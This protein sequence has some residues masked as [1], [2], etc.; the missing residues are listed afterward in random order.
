MIA[1][2]ESSGSRVSCVRSSSLRAPSSTL[3]WIGVPG[4]RAAH[5]RLEILDL[6]HRHVVDGGDH[7]AGAEAGAVGGRGAVDAVEA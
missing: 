3:R 1:R 4:L 5:L 6:R 7:H 2:F